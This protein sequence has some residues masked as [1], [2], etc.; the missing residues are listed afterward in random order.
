LVITPQE[1][2]EESQSPRYS[3]QATWPILEWGGD[4]RVQAF[5][6]AVETMVRE[7]IQTFKDGVL[8]LPDDPAL[9]EYASSLQ[10]SYTTQNYDRGILSVLLRISFYSA[11]AAHPG[12]Y[13][14]AVNYDL[15]EGKELALADLFQPGADYL[16]LLS[17]A[18]LEDLQNRHVLGWEEGALPKEENFRNWNVTPG[19]LLITFDEYQVAPYALGP[20]SV[21]IPYETL[22]ELLRPDGPLSGFL[23]PQGQP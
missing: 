17:S 10:I 7:E 23:D 22:S 20:Q 8:K 3:I 6:R 11:G 15:R 2:S 13:F 18:C 9:S 1:T 16:S 14:R 21:I 4:P 19:G 12:S 5:N